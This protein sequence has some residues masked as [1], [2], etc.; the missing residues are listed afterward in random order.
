VVREDDT[1]EALATRL[2]DYH[3]KTAP[4]LELFE[5][6]EFVA[7]FDAT[8]PIDVIQAEIRARFDLPPA[9]PPPAT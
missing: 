1:R 6:K 8:K 7:T 2:H 3:A 5:R 4:V 9:P